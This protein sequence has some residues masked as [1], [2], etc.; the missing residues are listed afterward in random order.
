ML[1]F[2]H[3][4]SWETEILIFD[5]CMPSL[6][7]SGTRVL[8]LCQRLQTLRHYLVVFSMVWL[9]FSLFKHVPEVTAVNTWHRLGLLYKQN[10][11]TS[12]LS[13][14]KAVR[15]KAVLVKCFLY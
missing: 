5:N 9:K 12:T 10:V 2:P 7:A 15:Q 4:C 3:G 13:R 8:K 6:E 11:P 1:F 14:A